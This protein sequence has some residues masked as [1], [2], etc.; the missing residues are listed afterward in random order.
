MVVCL[1][2]GLGLNATIARVGE[3]RS[4]HETIRSATSSRR[5]SARAARG[6]VARG[7][8]P[9]ARRPQRRRRPEGARRPHHPERPARREHG[10]RRCARTPTCCAPSAAS[11]P[12]RRRGSCPSRS[13][14]RSRSSSCRALFVVTTG[15]A[16]LQLKDLIGFL[17]HNRRR[18][19]IARHGAG[20][21][22]ADVPGIGRSERR[23]RADRLRVRATRT[24]RASAGCSAP[25][26]CRRGDGLWIVPAG[27]CTCSACAT[28]STSFS[29]TT[30][31]A[32]CDTIDGARAVAR[33]AA[34]SPTAT[35][36]IELPAGTL[37]R[38]GLAAGRAARDRER[39]A[40]RR[41]RR[42]GQ[43]RGVRPRRAERR[44]GGLLR[45]LRRGALGPPPG[46]PGQWGAVVPILLQETL[47]VAL[48]LLRR[49]SRDTSSRPADWL[50]GAAG[51][52]LPLLMRG[53]EALGPARLDRASPPDGGWSSRWSPC[54]PRAELRHR[55]RQP[56]RADG[57]AVSRRPPPALRGAMRSPTS[58]TCSATRAS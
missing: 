42:R 50:L 36:V 37:A 55:R 1:E 14:S 38:T 27:R 5:S 25:P 41:P 2:A 33:L 53:S 29:S 52:F 57:R 45:V 22:D 32:W 19:E 43:H 17:S 48:F 51:T 16:M 56:R 31:S 54:G 20:V 47:L 49:P 13:S 6:P 35:S 4:A 10:A 15:P 23:R 9:R 11:A 3:E 39:V 7:G 46:A 44:H 26:S 28:R 8:A 24:G 30:T 21:R 58:D 18:A 12:R 34:A 40:G